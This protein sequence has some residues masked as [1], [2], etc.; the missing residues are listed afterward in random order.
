MIK[1]DTLFCRTVMK[2]VLNLSMYETPNKRHVSITN[3]VVKFQLKIIWKHLMHIS[4]GNKYH[5]YSI[6]KTDNVTTV[7]YW[8]LF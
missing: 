1:H 5:R 2:Y 4:R 6:K 7:I 3:F 8:N